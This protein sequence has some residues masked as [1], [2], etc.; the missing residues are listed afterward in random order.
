[1]SYPGKDKNIPGRIIGPWR[2]ACYLG[3]L[4]RVSHASKM[5]QC[6]SF[7]FDKTISL[8]SAKR[9]RDVN[10]N[11]LGTANSTT[12]SIKNEA[13]K[14]RLVFK[15]PSN[16]TSSANSV[17]YVPTNFLEGLSPLAQSVLLNP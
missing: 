13:E 3:F 10:I 9:C 14:E 6:V 4:S 5:P 15:R 7:I 8:P 16:F 17:D 11:V 12:S 2:P 1:M